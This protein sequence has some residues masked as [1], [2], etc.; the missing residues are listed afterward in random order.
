M[1]GPKERFKLLVNANQMQIRGLILKLADKGIVLVEGSLRAITHYK[2]LVLSRMKWAEDKTATLIWQ[3]TQSKP[4]FIKL[5]WHECTTDSEARSL[6]HEVGFEHILKSAIE[7]AP[8]A[9][10]F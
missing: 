3:G 7:L 5:S 9:P 2:K 10:I 6:L 4:V 8:V 1:L